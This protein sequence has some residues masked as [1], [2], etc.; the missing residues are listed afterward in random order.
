[1]GVHRG[2][3]SAI[4]IKI[5]TYIIHVY[6]LETYSFWVIYCKLKNGENNN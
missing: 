1:M 4:I 5:V 2:R 3:E 6:V